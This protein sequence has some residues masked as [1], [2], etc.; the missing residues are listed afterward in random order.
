[1][2]SCMDRIVGLGVRQGL[3]GGGQETHRMGLCWKAEGFKGE[4]EA[5]RSCQQS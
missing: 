2:F 1:M 4:Q 5:G 3:H